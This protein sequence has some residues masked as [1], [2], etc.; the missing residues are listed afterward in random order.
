[1][2]VIDLRHQSRRLFRSQCALQRAVLW[3]TDHAAHESL[4]LEMSVDYVGCEKDQDN[5]PFIDDDDIEE[6]EEQPA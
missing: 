3:T 5:E 4:S 2:C 6:Q 1:M